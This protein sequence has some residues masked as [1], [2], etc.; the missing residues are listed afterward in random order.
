MG[1][2]ESKEEKINIDMYMWLLM[3]SY[4]SALCTTERVRKQVSQIDGL[5]QTVSRGWR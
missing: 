3:T 4:K 1:L 5:L 2:K